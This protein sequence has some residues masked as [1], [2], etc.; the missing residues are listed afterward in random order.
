[1]TGK[2]C[3]V[4]YS[5]ECSA[6]NPGRRRKATLTDAEA[7]DAMAG[8]VLAVTPAAQAEPAQEGGPEPTV[9]TTHSHS[10]AP[11]TPNVACTYLRSPHAR[12]SS[13]PTRQNA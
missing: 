4:R 10:P 7:V 5:G 2:C 6:R 12:P 9:R 13:A 11:A 1:M 8:M 3:A